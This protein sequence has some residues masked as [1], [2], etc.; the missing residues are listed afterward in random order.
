MCRVWFW[1]GSF[2][3]VALGLAVPEVPE[4]A[5]AGEPVQVLKVRTWQY[6]TTASPLILKEDTWAVFGGLGAVLDAIWL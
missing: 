2:A 3:G 5:T 4:P 1:L 6:A